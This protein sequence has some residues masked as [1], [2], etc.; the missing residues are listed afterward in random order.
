MHQ[1]T[2]ITITNISN[3]NV[4]DFALYRLWKTETNQFPSFPLCRCKQTIPKIDPPPPS[5]NRKR[6]SRTLSPGSEVTALFAPGDAAT[7]GGSSSRSSSLSFPDVT[8]S[9]LSSAD[10]HSLSN[11]DSS[12]DSSSSSA[13]EDSGVRSETKSLLSP[14]RDDDDDDDNNNDPFGERGTFLSASSRCH[15]P[16]EELVSHPGLAAPPTG[17]QASNT[18]NDTRLHISFSEDELL[19]SSPEEP[20]VTQR[21][22]EELAAST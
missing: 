20:G 5:L 1:Y 22:Q 9:S 10:F 13:S 4:P 14:L 19:E 17:P 16:Q 2:V 18:M 11:A 12:G 3:E 15:S 8:P 7:N 6:A 21:S